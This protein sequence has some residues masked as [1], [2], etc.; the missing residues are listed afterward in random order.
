MWSEKRAVVLLLH[1]GGWRSGDRSM[2]LPM[3]LKIAEAGFICCCVEYR[4]SPEARF[5]AAV[6][7]IKTAIRFC[8]SNA[9]QFNID[10]TR[11]ILYGTSAGGQLAALVGISQA[12]GH[13]TEQGEYRDHSNEVQGIIDIDGVLDMT[14]PAESGKDTLPG[15]PSVGKLWLG[16]TFSENP[17]IWRR[18]SA[19]NY[20]TRKSPPML[21]INSSHPRFH[22]GR[23]S[24]IN[25]LK[26]YGIYSEVH[27]IANTPHPFWL[28]HPWFDEAIK[29]I[30]VF[31]SRFRK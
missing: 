13:F 26:K 12:G 10:T 8:R 31:L 25:M 30:Q 18:A 24:V 7:D 22:A 21:F 3:A 4:L 1:G 11:I 15:Q 9:A 17:S 6:Y 23:D 5:P 2:E 19:I 16:A 28:F 14:D 20:V 27:T 29:H